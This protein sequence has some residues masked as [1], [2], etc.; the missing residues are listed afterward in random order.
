MG[1]AGKFCSDIGLKLYRGFVIEKDLNQSEVNLIKINSILIVLRHRMGDMLCAL[2]MMNSVRKKFPF[3]KITLLTND[4][5]RFGEIFK[6]V[7]SPVDDVLLFESG[8]ENYFRVL[9][10]LQ[11]QNFDLAIVPSTVSFSG[12]NHLFAYHS[13]A[14]IRAG[15]RSKDYDKNPVRYLLNVKNDFTWGVKKI[16]QV[17]RNLDIL[18]QLNIEP[19]VNGIHLELSSERIEFAEIFLKTNFPDKKKKIIGFHPG[20][21][22]PANVWPPERFAELAMRLHQKFNNYFYVSEGPSD[23]PYTSQL[24]NLLIEKYGIHD[25]VLHR[26]KLMDT[27]AIIDKLDLFITNDTGVMH[28]SSG[29]KQPVIALFGET[30]AYEWG[31]AG[32]NKFSIQSPNGKMDGINTN[33]VYEV[34]QKLLK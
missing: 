20:A 26:G 33:T 4:S 10:Q 9:K 22:K 19:A 25:A 24:K 8:F 27:A 3:A 2:P 28:I 21:G 29:L 30:F 16:H 34:T 1:A 6:G 15:V 17:E 12:T 18:R 7:S 13:H 32:E 23:L 5:T 14:K 11:Q 31:P